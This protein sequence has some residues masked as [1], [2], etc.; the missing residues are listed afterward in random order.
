[1]RERV[2]ENVFGEPDTPKDII[3]LWNYL[4]VDIRTYEEMWKRV[5]PD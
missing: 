3:E 1:M 4:K 2:I 5:T